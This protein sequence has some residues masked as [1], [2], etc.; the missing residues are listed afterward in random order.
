[1]EASPEDIHQGPPHK[2]DAWHAADR[3]QAFPLK[4][5][6]AGLHRE[7]WESQSLVSVARFAPVGGE[8]R[9]AGPLR[10][11]PAQRSRFERLSSSPQCRARAPVLRS[12]ASPSAAPRPPPPAAVEAFASNRPLTIGARPVNWANLVGNVRSIARSRAGQR[13]SNRSNQRTAVRCP[14]ISDGDSTWDV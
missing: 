1:M 4:R 9:R 10:P 7:R 14:R 11:R 3:P 6:A 13:R 12:P 2:E 8:Y 5:T